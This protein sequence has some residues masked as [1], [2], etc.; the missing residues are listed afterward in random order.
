MTDFI[1][2]AALAPMDL[3]DVAAEDVVQF[4]PTHPATGQPIIG[5]DGK[6]WTWTI[7]GPGHDVAVR[8]RN[9]SM[10]EALKE[11]R[12]PQREREAIDE[13]E[14]IRKGTAFA[15]VRVLGWS[16][17]VFGGRELQF[18]SK[19]VVDLLG[20]PKFSWLAGQLNRFLQDDASFLRQ[21]PTT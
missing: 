13:Q 4:E 7:A 16:A 10:R 12:R 8:Q 14:T 6:P 9:A 2:G 1:D 3:A 5:A 15:A 18:S 19:A 17:V 20:N 11:Q 21:S